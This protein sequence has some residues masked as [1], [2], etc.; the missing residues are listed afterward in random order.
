MLQGVF[1][2]FPLA[3][4]KHETRRLKMTPESVH[5]FCM[6]LM[7]V[8]FLS[9]FFISLDCRGFHETRRLKMTSD[10]IKHGKGTVF[11]VKIEP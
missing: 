9:P 6:Q 2:S 5:L 7:H 10:L 8:L 3:W 1:F 11:C 4:I